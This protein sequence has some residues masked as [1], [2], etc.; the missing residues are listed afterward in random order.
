MS[1]ELAQHLKTTIK[2]EG[3]RHVPNAPPVPVPQRKVLPTL[4]TLAADVVMVDEN[5]E[6][7]AECTMEQVQ[8]QRQEREDNGVEDN[9]ESMQPPQQ[10]KVDKTLVGKRLKICW[11]FELKVGGEVLR[12]C[13][14]V[15]TE[16]SDGTN[17]M[18]K[19]AFHK[20]G[21]AVMF[22][23]DATEDRHKEE[24]T[25]KVELKRSLWNPKNNH[26]HGCWRM[27]MSLYLKNR[28]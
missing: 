8:V 3:K 24:H 12:W 13:P 4:G 20:L 28:T 17:T 18:K 14:G 26:S 9:V 15:V 25:W 22:K 7:S 6:F 1:D 10:P 5:D 21:E 2:A 27:D 16:V 19:R 11:K 23:F